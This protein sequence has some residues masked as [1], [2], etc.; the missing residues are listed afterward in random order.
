MEPI[1]YDKE[2]VR[3]GLTAD[4]RLERRKLHVLTHGLHYGS[5]VFEGERVYNGE[6]QI[7]R[8]HRQTY[9]FCEKNGFKIPYTADEIDKACNEL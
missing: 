3:S 7:K 8:A 6:I 1:P 9:L 5:C 4:S 2:M